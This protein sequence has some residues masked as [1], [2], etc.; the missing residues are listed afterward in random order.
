MIKIAVCDDEKNDRER[1][2]K[3]LLLYAEK[4]AE[5]YDIQLFASGEELLKSRMI[6]DIL[7]LDIIMEEK[8]GIQVG[9]EMKNHQWNV[10]IIYVTNLSEKM[11][12]AFN[13]IHSFGYLVK[14]IA[15][16]ELFQMMSDATLQ[17]KHALKTDIV[18]F[19]SE[20]RTIIQLS[21][22]DIYYFEYINKKIKI[23]AKDG[24]YICMKDRMKDVE[25]KMLEYGFAMSHRSFVVNLYHV[26]KILSQSLVIKNGDVVDLAQK[27]ASDFRKQLIEIA[28]KLSESSHVGKRR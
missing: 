8:N 22:S 27:R 15:E 28:R 14:P 13:Q 2:Y 9:R 20:D 1:L 24:V 19:L 7:F 10:M 3:L 21:A 18:T 17:M 4:D 26:D 6:P 5:D 11:A 16:Q 12:V 23:V 25:N